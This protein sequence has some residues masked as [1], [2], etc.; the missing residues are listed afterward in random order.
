MITDE[1]LNEVFY[2]ASHWMNNVLRV[3][4]GALDQDGFR[5]YNP[6][7]ADMREQLD[8][9]INNDWTGEQVQSFLG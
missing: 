5:I 8:E 3:T 9:L 4:Y 6:S 7:K 1:Q 2:N